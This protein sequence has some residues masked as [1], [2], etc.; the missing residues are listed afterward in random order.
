MAREFLP[1]ELTLSRVQ[2]QAIGSV[3]VESAYLDFFVE[4]LIWDICSLD[5]PTGKCFTKNLQLKGKLELL[6]DVAKPKIK[7]KR[8]L[9]LFTKIISELKEANENRN[10]IVHGIWAPKTPISKKGWLRDHDA[11]AIKD[12]LKTG[13]RLFPVSE[14]RATAKK[15]VWGIWA[16]L[17]FSQLENWQPRASPNK[18]QSRPDVH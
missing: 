5:T 4:G 8:R 13:P 11:I 12:R 17:K 7:D 16:L 6:S 15:L 2:L 14:I 3:A 1:S 18:S 9:A 10:A